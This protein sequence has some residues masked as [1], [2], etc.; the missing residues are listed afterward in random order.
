MTNT[1]HWRLEQSYA[2]LP[3]FLYSRVRPEIPPSPRLLLFNHTLAAELGLTGYDKPI[4]RVQWSA[5]LSGKQLPPGAV[6]IAQAYAGHQF[7]Y[8]T[9][10][11]DGR[12]ILLGEQVCGNKHSFDIQL[13]GAGRTPYSRRADGRATL[14]SMLREY[15]ISEA[16]FGLG[17]PGSRS[18]AVC[19]TG[20]QVQRESPQPGAVLT[21]VMQSHLRVG[22]F[23]YVRQFGSP[24]DPGILIRYAL[25]KLYPDVDAGERPGLTLLKATSQR[26][27]RLMA[28]WMGAGFV[29]GVMNTDNMS[30]SGETFDYGPCAF[31]NDYDPDKVYSSIDHYGRYAFGRQPQIAQWN[32]SVLAGALLSGIDPDEEKAAGMAREVLHEFAGDYETAW[33]Q[34]MGQKIG[35]KNAGPADKPL[36]KGLLDLMQQHKA[37]Y[38]NSFLFLMNLP[39]P[40]AEMYNDAEFR[41]WLAKRSQRLNL[42]GSHPADALK[43]MKA[44]NPV[45]I[46]RNHLVEEALMAA[47]EGPDHEKWDFSAF[48]SLLQRLQKPYE[49]QEE[50]EKYISGP[51]GGEAHYQTFCGT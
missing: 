18:L 44:V 9:M 13:K 28:Q 25:N 35:L 1:T 51:P 16:V 2:T 43:R 14:Y 41:Q 4:D 37:D 24:D 19:A 20:E 6:P 12:A 22:T 38:T 50:S 46:P 30:L 40:Q 7:G 3:G 15:L 48:N 32:L 5:W 42:E 31:I 21:R 27:A 36:I 45:Y 47:S 10:L 39:V 49:W 8:F 29:H 34:H 33:L 23:E 17:I 26:Q 11:G